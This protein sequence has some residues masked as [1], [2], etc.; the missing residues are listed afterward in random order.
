MRKTLVF[1]AWLLAGSAWAQ[2]C[3]VL[4]NCSFETPALGSYQYNPT[5]AGIAW[6]FSAS[7]GIEHN[8]S[9]WTAASAPGGTQ[10]AFVQGVGS[11]SQ[12]V[13]LTAGTY[14]LTFQA[15]GRNAGC[16][17]RPNI[18]PIKVM[19]D[20]NQVGSTI[21]PPSTMFAPYSVSFSVATGGSH[22]ISFAG[23]V[24]V[25]KT[26]FIDAVSLSGGGGGGPIATTTA[27]V[28]TLNPSTVGTNV[29][30]AA[31]V[32]GNSP[33]GTVRFAFDGTTASGC[34]AVP[35]SGA[36]AGCMTNSLAAGT[37]SVVGTYS[38]DPNNS[39]SISPPLS[40]VVNSTPPPPPN[41]GAITI[42]E[43]VAAPNSAVP[44]D[45]LVAGNSA[46]NV[47]VALVPKG[48]GAILAQIPD[49][50]VAAGAKR[51]PYAVDL[52]RT[53]I[54]STDIAS[55]YGATISGG[56]NNVASGLYATVV[57]GFE[58]E[59]SGHVAV[60]GGQNA[61]ASGSGTPVAL[62]FN[63]TA[64]GDSAVAL[65][66]DPK[67]TGT[68]SVAIGR[69]N[70][71]TRDNSVAIGWDNLSDA[72]QSV[73][74]G[75][76]STTRGVHGAIV[77]ADGQIAVRGDNQHGLYIVKAL[78]G[79]GTAQLTM[80]GSP[81]ALCCGNLLTVAENASY[82]FTGKAVARDLNTGDS[83]AWRFE[84]LVKR[85]AG[86][87]TGTP[88]S[89]SISLVSVVVTPIP[90]TAGAVAWVLSFAANTGTGALDVT[91]TGQAGR[92]IQWVATVE[93]V[94]NVG[95]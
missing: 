62:G 86:T 57:G 25:D 77:F 45:A 37:H 83:A 85:E 67:A 60:A 38:G 4:V 81:P 41:S 52:Q 47:D 58:N 78:S 15:A 27:L 94:E 66:H 43:S 95:D 39:S 20:G 82:V 79:T 50:A 36:I 5:G 32:N 76:Q 22:T 71:A 23:T 28:S 75:T 92:T 3:Q 21:T 14:T 74:L 24:A 65:G 73:A 64:S 90:S 46:I 51:G 89:A 69:L 10:A 61:V 88:G 54:Y 31:T 48:S 18:Q 9:A 19:I 56:A 55:G 42:T 11:I 87:A 17:T 93:T 40:Q 7:S 1:A 8:G 59:A 33:T 70:V 26:T 6:T 72:T 49:G 30:F 44:V 53:R 80:S 63:A 16:C 34:S 91:G 2:S 12:A 29:T 68:D 84:G 13:N 35:L